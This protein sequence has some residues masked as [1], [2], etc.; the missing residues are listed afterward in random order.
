M[1]SEQTQITTKYCKTCKTI[2][3]LIEFDRYGNTYRQHCRI[4]RGNP[5]YIVRA[6]NKDEM[7]KRRKMLND[8]DEKYRNSLRIIQEQMAEIEAVHAQLVNMHITV[9]GK[10]NDEETKEEENKE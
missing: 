6:N 3:P 1:S 9:I 2:K 4:C 8:L 10:E 7:T 5:I